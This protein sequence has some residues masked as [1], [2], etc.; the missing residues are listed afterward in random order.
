ML[1]QNIATLD[2]IFVCRSWPY[3]IGT[4]DIETYLEKM[5]PGLIKIDRTL[6]QK[7]SVFCCQNLGLWCSNI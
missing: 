7:L 2:E 3:D 4:N 5:T 1:T 6:P